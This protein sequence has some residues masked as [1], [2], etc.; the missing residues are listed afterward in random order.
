VTAPARTRQS[1][2]ERRETVL[3][4]AVAAFAVGG[5]SGTRTEDI[6]NAAGI[7]HAYVFRLYPTKKE[8][9]LACVDR[10]FDRTEETFRAAVADPADG[11]TRTQ[12]MGS[13]YIAMLEDR[14][15][16]LMQLQIYAAAEDPD[17]RAKARSRYERLREEIASLRGDGDD[18]AVEFIGQGMLLNVV[19]ALGLD[20]EAWIW[21]KDPA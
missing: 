6:A 18:A 8:L 7:S 5:Y 3:Q 15:L 10:C 9:F 16:L 19:A 21:D 1:A 14:E 11:L 20:P 12:A 4:K 2:A 13:A 17:V